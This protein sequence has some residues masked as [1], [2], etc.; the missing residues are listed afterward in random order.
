M[1]R[2]G[3]PLKLSL[4]CVRFGSSFSKEHQMAKIAASARWLLPPLGSRPE[5]IDPP[6]CP[7]PALAGLSPL[8]KPREACSDC[9][10]DT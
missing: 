7:P 3:A 6:E 4:P 5:Q 10:L 2:G 9:R 8:P 1:M